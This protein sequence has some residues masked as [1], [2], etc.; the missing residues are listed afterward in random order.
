MSKEKK[1]T[2]IQEFDHHIGEAFGAVA[3]SAIAWIALFV[4][5]DGYKMLG[6]SPVMVVLAILFH[7]TLLYMLYRSSKSKNPTL[8]VIALS[9][10][11]LEFGLT[12]FF[13]FAEAMETHRG[14]ES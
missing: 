13:G 7:V 4:F 14:A 9:I 3:L 5:A 1:L 11:V 12:V 8:A 2:P 10:L 6:K